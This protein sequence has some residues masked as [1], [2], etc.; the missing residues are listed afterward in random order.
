MHSKVK[1]KKKKE[2]KY[3]QTN[4]FD[5][6]SWRLG[7]TWNLNFDFKFQV[8]WGHQD[9]KTNSFVCFLGEVTARQFYFEIYWTLSPMKLWVKW[10]T[11]LI[12]IAA[13]TAAAASA[14]FVATSSLEAIRD[15][16]WPRR[17]WWPLHFLHV[18]LILKQLFIS[19]YWAQPKVE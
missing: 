14:S 15:S 1:F 4:E 7:N 3:S 13:S 8:F 11:V 19:H 6:L 12:L 18:L 17:L 16:Q 10:F 2:K 9:R 5:F